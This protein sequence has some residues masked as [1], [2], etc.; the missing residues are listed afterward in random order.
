ML[1]LGCVAVLFRG[2]SIDFFLYGQGSV[3]FITF[4]SQL[5]ISPLRHA[6]GIWGEA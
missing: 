6:A 4:V 5:D 3:K 1:E 2:L